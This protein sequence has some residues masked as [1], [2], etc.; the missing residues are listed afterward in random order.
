MRSSCKP[1][2]G[3]PIGTYLTLVRVLLAISSSWS[4]FHF[5]KESPG[6]VLGGMEC[7]VLAINAGQKVVSWNPTTSVS[8]AHG[9]PRWI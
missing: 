3:D 8:T 5:D 6:A 4:L 1:I 7:V 2:A 9:G